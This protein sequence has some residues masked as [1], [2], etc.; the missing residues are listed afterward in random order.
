MPRNNSKARKEQRRYSAEVRR[1]IQDRAIRTYE[2]KLV[3][4]ENIKAD[5]LLKRIAREVARINAVER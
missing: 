5:L 4:A 1:V 2:E 3:V